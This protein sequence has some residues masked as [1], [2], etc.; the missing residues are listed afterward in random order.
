MNLLNVPE[1]V[2]FLLAG[3]ILPIVWAVRSGA[4]RR[5]FLPTQR[6]ER[7]PRT[8][9]GTVVTP[10]K[11]SASSA[12]HTPRTAP[13]REQKAVA[14]PEP[15]PAPK[16]PK[17]SKSPK[18]APKATTPYVAPKPYSMPKMS[19]RFIART[20]SAARKHQRDSRTG[21]VT[22]V[23]RDSRLADDGTTYVTWEHLISG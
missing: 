4:W 16:P 22:T 3:G 8:V 15:K 20:R 12:I 19:R 7:T 1:W 18:P 5:L 14:K 9:K 13:Q 10:P 6:T 21:L 17:L 11:V 23:E 2:V